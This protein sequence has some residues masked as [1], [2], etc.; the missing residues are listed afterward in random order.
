MLQG[1]PSA[2]KN[3]SKYRP[4]GKGDLNLLSLDKINQKANVPLIVYQQNK[5]SMAAEETF[6]PRDVRGLMDTGAATNFVSTNFIKRYNIVTYSFEMS[7]LAKLAKLKKLCV[8]STLHGAKCAESRNV[9]RLNIQHVGTLIPEYSAEFVVGPFDDDIIVGRHTLAKHNSLLGYPEQFFN[10]S[11]GQTP[12]I[13][14]ILWGVSADSQSI[15]GSHTLGL[16]IDSTSCFCSSKS[17]GGVV[18]D[19]QP[20]NFSDINSYGGLTAKLTPFPTSEEGGDEINQVRWR[21]NTPNNKRMRAGVLSQKEKIIVRPRQTVQLSDE[22]GNKDTS[23]RTSSSRSSAALNSLNTT[24]PEFATRSD[25]GDASN[26]SQSEEH[27]LHDGH[28]EIHRSLPSSFSKNYSPI[29][30]FAR[31]DEISSILKLTTKIYGPLSLQ[32]A[33]KKILYEFKD[34]FSIKVST[35]SPADVTPFNLTV[36]ERLW[37]TQENKTDARR[38]DSSR[39]FEIKQQRNSLKLDQRKTNN[40]ER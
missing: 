22:Q 23:G 38:Y 32:T 5:A 40:L 2:D 33:I 1:T 24:S 29:N 4:Q 13:N 8:C 19:D 30:T 34:M 15:A 25:D 21:E 35:T 37:E 31:E 27:E 26:E 6:N 11:P 17:T 20:S 36:D 10:L 14:K 12:A 28:A 3:M 9:A 18:D 39:A 16:H 7:E